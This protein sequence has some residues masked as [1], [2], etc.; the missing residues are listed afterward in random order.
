M[1]GLRSNLILLV[2]AASLGAYIY[3]VER[4]RAPASEA[5]P[6]E[7]LFNFEAEDI[8]NLQITASDGSVS[9]LQQNASGEWAL[10][11]PVQAVAEDTTVSRFSSQPIRP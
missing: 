11:E 3:F 4:H 8:S 7:R 6:N 1:R 10:V 9:Q 5:T 2:V